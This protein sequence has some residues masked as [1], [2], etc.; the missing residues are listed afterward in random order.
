MANGYIELLTDK[1]DKRNKLITL[2]PKGNAYPIVAL[3]QAV[4]TG[5]IPFIRNFG[6]SNFAMV[7]GRPIA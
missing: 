2:T 4:G 3:I 5:L 6:N 1:E 7:A